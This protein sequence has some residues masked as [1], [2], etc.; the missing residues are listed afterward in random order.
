MMMKGVTLLA[1]LLSVTACDS[2]SDRVLEID[3]NAGDINLADMVDGDWDRLCLFP[4]YANNK[5]AAERLGFAWDLEATSRIDTWDA[6][7]LLVFSQ[8][9]KVRFF[10]EVPRWADFAHLA[11]HCFERSNAHFN[12][13]SGVVAHLPNKA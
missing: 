10:Y 12:V 4:P 13:R 5:M 6:I 2:H 11:G 3:K 7:T 1:L 9:G 8:Q